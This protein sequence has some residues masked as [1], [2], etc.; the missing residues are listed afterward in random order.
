MTN[1]RQIALA[2]QRGRRFFKA[3]K[4]L[5]DAGP[6]TREQLIAITEQ[7]KLSKTIPD[8]LVSSG[9]LK[10]YEL[11]DGITEAKPMESM[12]SGKPYLAYWNDQ[13]DDEMAF[14]TVLSAWFTEKLNAFDRFRESCKL[15][16]Y[17]HCKRCDAIFTSRLGKKYCSDKC[18]ALDHYHNKEQKTANPTLK[19]RV[20]CVLKSIRDFVRAL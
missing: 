10:V 8:S 11:P 17:S 16:H 14:Y 9:V 15:P 18:R 5:T 12:E 6:V 4:T 1:H 7:H 13:P 2:I 20:L 19:E 3:L